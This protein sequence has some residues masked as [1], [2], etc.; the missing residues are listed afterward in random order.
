MTVAG[1][2][3]EDARCPNTV[4]IVLD[5]PRTL[6]T[7]T[8]TC[9]SLLEALTLHPAV[10][11]DCTAATDI[12]LSFIQLLVAAR[13]TAGQASRT[14]TL[15]ENPDGVLLAALSRAGLRSVKLALPGGTD[16][17]WFEGAQV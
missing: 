8:E 11:I 12:D 17:F 14:V 2:L 7:A 10:S 6:R 9:T 16:D 5:G 3:G 13:N 4:Q 15:A 1:E